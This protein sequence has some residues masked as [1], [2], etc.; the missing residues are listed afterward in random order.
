[1]RQMFTVTAYELGSLITPSR[2]RFGWI[3]KG[4]IIW[5]NQNIH[6]S[7]ALKQSLVIGGKIKEE[8]GG[9]SLFR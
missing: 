2:R 6:K 5:L 8:R 9:C 7:F 4:R 1:M 3:H